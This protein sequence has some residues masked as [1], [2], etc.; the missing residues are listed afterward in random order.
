MNTVDLTAYDKDRFTSR[1]FDPLVAVSNGRLLTFNHPRFTRIF[2][3]DGGTLPSYLAKSFRVTNNGDTELGITQKSIV[4]SRYFDDQMP[5][6]SPDS[7]SL[8]VDMVTETTPFGTSQALR[9]THVADTAVW[10]TIPGFTGLVDLS[11]V[12]YFKISN[13]GSDLTPI[14]IYNNRASIDISHPAAAI[15]IKPDGTI[16]AR[17]GYIDY[18]PSGQTPVQADAWHRATIS[19]NADSTFSIQVDRFIADAFVPLIT[20][21]E[22]Y[23]SKGSGLMDE[24]TGDHVVAVA[25]EGPGVQTVDSLE[26]YQFGDVSE[27][28]APKQTREYFCHNSLDEFSSDGAV[29]GYYKL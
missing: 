15:R 13:F 9:L 16:T 19:R 24:I 25:S 12:I 3:S 18:T 8:D 26:V 23:T 29:I 14:G 21:D 1:D 5:G 4:F 28:L 17:K 10:T 2:G 27:P 11:Y 6:V 7:P 22:T 20:S